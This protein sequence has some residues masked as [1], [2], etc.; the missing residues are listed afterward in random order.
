MNLAAEGTIDE[1]IISAL[2]NKKDVADTIVN[3]GLKLFGE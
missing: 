1:K 2:T 3:I